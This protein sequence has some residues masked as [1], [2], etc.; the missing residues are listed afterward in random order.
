MKASVSVQA[1]LL[2][3]MGLVGLCHC[4][5]KSGSE[6]SITS[7]ESAN[8]TDAE[9]M[10]AYKD[11]I[12]DMLTRPAREQAPARPAGLYV[13]D[14]AVRILAPQKY[15]PYAISGA[16]YVYNFPGKAWQICLRG[17]AE[18]KPYYFAVFIRR[19]QV[20]NVRGEIFTDKCP[21]QTYEPFPV[22]FASV[23]Q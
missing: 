11:L 8:T 21:E 12:R 13:Y 4:S 5:T 6:N 19:N 9:P 2:V 3:A 23:Q 20:I 18:G 16:R 14:P 15:A 1:A 17:T 7:Q 22:N 10:P